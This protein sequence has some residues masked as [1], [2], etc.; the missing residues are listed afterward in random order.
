M[1]VDS[2][3]TSH[4]DYKGEQALHRAKGKGVILHDTKKMYWIGHVLRRNLNQKHL[5]EGKIQGWME[6][7]GRRGRRQEATA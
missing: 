5:T 4:R 3:G 1:T 6:V 7:T 2:A